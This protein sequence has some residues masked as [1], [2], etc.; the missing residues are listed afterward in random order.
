MMFLKIII[1][2]QLKKLFKNKLGKKIINIQEKY[3]KKRNNFMR[4]FKGKKN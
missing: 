3:L 4:I 1:L 2:I